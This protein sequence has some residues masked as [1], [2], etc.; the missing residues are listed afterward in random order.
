MSEK[1]LLPD[2]D[3]SVY[4]TICRLEWSKSVSTQFGF[5][6]PDLLALPLQQEFHDHIILPV[7]FSFLVEEYNQETLK[8]LDFNLERDYKNSTGVPLGGVSTQY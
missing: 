7:F 4:K 3:V 6:S 2:P 1:K 8:L 5:A